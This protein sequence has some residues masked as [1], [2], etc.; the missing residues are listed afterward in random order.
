M[1]RGER[2]TAASDLF[3]FGVVLWELLTWELPWGPMNPWQV[4]SSLHCNVCGTLKHPPAA[5]AAHTCAHFWHCRIACMHGGN[6]AVPGEVMVEP[7]L[8]P[9]QLAATVAAGGRLEVPPLHDLPGV[10]TP[11]V[12]IVWMGALCMGVGVVG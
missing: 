8:L 4:G 9:L 1:L 3:A 10:D 6:S 5:A 12:G 7:L 2:P 11:Q